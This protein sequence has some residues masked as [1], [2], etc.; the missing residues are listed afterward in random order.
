MVL[1]SLRTV[2]TA[3]GVVGVLVPVKGVLLFGSG[4]HWR[5]SGSEGR[6]CDKVWQEGEQWSEESLRVT[7][8][9]GM[10][11]GMAMCSV[12]LCLACPDVTSRVQGR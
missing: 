11:S 10:G 6:G 3:E 5:V 7:E 9:I 12:G 4:W 1:A 2:S 8:V